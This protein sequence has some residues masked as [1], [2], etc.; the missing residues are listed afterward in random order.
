MHTRHSLGS[1]LVGLAALC[2]ALAN[3]GCSSGEAPGETP[4][5]DFRG[6][7]T[8]TSE[9]A[10]AGIAFA[11]D[12]TYLL[13]PKACR[14]EAC[15]ERGTYRYDAS[16]K[17]LLLTDAA[18]GAV[19]TMSVEVIATTRSTGSTSLV[20]Q[21]LAPQG[22]LLPG[23]SSTPN[24]G[25]SSKLAEGGDSKLTQ[26]D[27]KLA[28]GDSKLTEAAS[29]LLTKILEALLDK[30]GM[31]GEDDEKDD[32]D[33][34]KDPQPPQNPDPNDCRASFPTPQTPP[35]DARAYWDRCP[36]GVNTPPKN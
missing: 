36:A 17:A 5:V 11:D 1:A 25:G 7:Y 18:T 30:Q 12:H 21:S 20:K 32:G 29:Q 31:K 35:A 23:G 2:A 10:L 34:G 28:Q 4:P 6:V 3:N 14:A 8:S 16:R 26:G 33:Q 15:T 19:R 27:S 13:Q 9:G 24:P 22:E